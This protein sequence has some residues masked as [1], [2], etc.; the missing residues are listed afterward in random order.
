MRKIKENICPQNSTCMNVKNC[1][2]NLIEEL[3]Y[4]FPAPMIENEKCTY[5]EKCTAAHIKSCS[6]E[7]K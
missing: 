6:I 4:G 7:K 3:G 5:C 2:A 1:C